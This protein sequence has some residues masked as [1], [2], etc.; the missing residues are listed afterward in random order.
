MAVRAVKTKETIAKPKNK[1]PRE[2]QQS[3]HIPTAIRDK[4]YARDGGRYTFVGAD[5][6]KC[7]S[8]WDVQ[9]DHIKPYARGGDHTVCNLR[10]LCAKHNKLAAERIY[11][12]GCIEQRICKP[13]PV[14]K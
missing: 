8:T 10:L 12:K 9:I 6:V 1:A 4:V 2:K 5:G 7:N 14:R 3:R 11:G 13:V